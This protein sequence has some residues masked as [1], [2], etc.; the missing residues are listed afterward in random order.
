MENMSYTQGEI[1]SSSL[2]HHL[3]TY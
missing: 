2:A 1:P 3:S